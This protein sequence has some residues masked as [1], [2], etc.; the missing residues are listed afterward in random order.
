YDD[1]WRQPGLGIEEHL[2]EHADV[3]IFLSGGWYVSYT[4]ATLEAYQPPER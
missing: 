2:T 1:Y 3:P 4:R